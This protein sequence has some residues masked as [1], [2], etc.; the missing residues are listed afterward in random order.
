MLKFVEYAW[1]IIAVISAIELYRMWDNFDKQFWLF[2]GFMLF[3]IFM[4]FLRR[5]QRQR[6]DARRREKEGEEA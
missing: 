3:A 4:F 6:Y 2:F 5:R 1:I